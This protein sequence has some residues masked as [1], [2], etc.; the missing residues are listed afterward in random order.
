M[1]LH[2]SVGLARTFRILFRLSTH[3]SFL[4]FGVRTWYFVFLWMKINANYSW[5]FR[6]FVKSNAG[7]GGRAREAFHKTYIVKSAFILKTV[8]QFQRHKARVCLVL[9]A[10]LSATYPFKSI[11]NIWITWRPYKLEINKPNIFHN[12]ARQVCIWD[13]IPGQETI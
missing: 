12:Y 13:R 8:R 2:L 5:H 1:F 6:P 9:H 3:A 10:F 7:G 4:F 11:E